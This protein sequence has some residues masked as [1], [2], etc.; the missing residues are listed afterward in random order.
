MEVECGEEG[1]ACSYRIYNVDRNVLCSSR[2]SLFLVLSPSV[3]VPVMAFST[4]G[5]STFAAEKGRPRL[6][7]GEGRELANWDLH[8]QEWADARRTWIKLLVRCVGDCLADDEGTEG[9]LH[10]PLSFV[11]LTSRLP[12]DFKKWGAP[13]A[14]L[15][16]P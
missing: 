13:L 1:D 9:D 11:R 6:G 3:A 2:F 7:R 4:G 16:T 12:L 14:L 10:R 5:Y 15:L 8:A